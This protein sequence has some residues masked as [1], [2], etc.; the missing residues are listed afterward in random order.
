MADDYEGA[1]KAVEH[2]IK[3]GRRK[4]AHFAGPPL[5]QISRNRIDGYK[6]ALLK[7]GL[8]F[9]E[10]L[11]IDCGSGLEQENGSKAA[12]DMLDAGIRPDAIFAICDPI[13]IGVMMTLKRNNIRIPYEISVVG[14]CDEPVAKVVEPQLST[15]VQPA[16]Q[17]GETSVELLLKQ[18]G[19]PSPLVEKKVLST[20]LKVRESSISHYSSHPTPSVA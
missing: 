4:I 16:F 11:L 19:N 12:Q 2:L 3:E 13:A 18:I 6:D 20:E 9:D 15:L 14:F 7:H 10:S 5:L 8:P 1:F 17:I